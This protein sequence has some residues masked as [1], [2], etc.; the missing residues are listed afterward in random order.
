MNYRKQGKKKIIRHIISTPFIWA[1]LPF[2]MMLDLILEIYHQVGF[3][4]YGLELVKRADY[5]QIVDRQKLQ[6]L[7]LMQKLG[8]MYCGYVNGFLRYAKEVAGKTE[9]YWC[10][11]MHEKIHP[12]EHLQ[13]GFV[14]YNSKE[15]WEAK[16]PLDSE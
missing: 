3:R 11:I 9:E 8:C 12:A 6:Y 10:G 16:Y 13:R 15:A 5:I 4:L 1:P 7:N 14:Q 2:V